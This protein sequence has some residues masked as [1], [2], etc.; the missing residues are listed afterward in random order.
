MRFIVHGAG[1]IGGVVGGRLHAAGYD[2][3]LIARG[4]HARAMRDRGLRILDPAGEETVHAPVVEHPD[5]IAFADG[6]V[7]LLCVKTQDSEAALRDLAGAAPVSTPVVCAQNGVANEDF[8]LR[9]FDNVYGMNVMCPALY[10]E[11]GVVQVHSAPVAGTFDLG[12]YPH[13]VDD[14]AVKT[15]AAFSDATFLAEPR[16]DIM[17]W[18]YGKLLYNLANSLEALC[19]PESRRGP[20]AK[21]LRAETDACYAAAG[22]EPQLE[23]ADSPRHGVVVDLPVGG[24]DRAGGSSYQSLLRG[25]GGIE[26]DYLNGEIARLGRLHGVP[27]PVNAALQRMANRHARDRMPPGVLTD[28]DVLREAGVSLDR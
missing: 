27:T 10:A 14:T 3:V 16:A 9:S 2:V 11:P 26:A 4:A 17:P 28:A 20:V 19:G 25:T 12:R 15:A 8:A 22:I 13:G 6:D 24:T 7:V 5:E 21:L 23:P 18:K 1:A